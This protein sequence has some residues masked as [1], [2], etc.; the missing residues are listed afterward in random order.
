MNGE[1][2]VMEL[3]LDGLG[4]YEW[5]LDGLGEYEWDL[6]DPEELEWEGDD[7]LY[8]ADPFF[9]RILRSP[10]FKQLAR[11]AAVAVGRKVGGRKGGQIAARIAKRVIREG[12]FEGEYEYELFED[13]FEAEGG[14]LE[15]L[16][17]METLAELAAESESEA[18][19]DEFL[20]ALA[21]MAGPLISSLLGESEYED[22]LE[23][24][25]YE[26]DFELYEAEGDEFFGALASLIPAAIPLVKSGARAL[27]RLFSRRRRRRRSRREAEA[28]I[29]AIPKIVA[30][31]GV[32]LKRQAKAG[33]PVTRKKVA[34]VMA[35]TTAKTLANPRALAKAVKPTRAK[36]RRVRSKVRRGLTP[37]AARHLRRTRRRVL[38]A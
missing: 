11:Q 21:S 15:L 5:E 24:Y 26:D 12:E 8:E 32:T 10:Q 4:E 3:E 18:E 19:A 36:V 29:K 33:K 37:R 13:E 17:E 1:F 9:G 25:E 6:E 22:E 35:K 30:K 34:A 2:G 27:G 38:P 20:G 23:L 28:A 14:D 31:T 7:E 16:E